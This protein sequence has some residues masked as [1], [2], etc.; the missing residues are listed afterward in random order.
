MPAGVAEQNAKLTIFNAARRPALLPFDAHR[1]RA[2]LEQARLID[3]QDCVGIGQVLDH[4]GAQVVPHSVGI[5]VSRVEQTLHTVGGCFTK[6]L[7]AV[8]AVFAFHGT[9]PCLR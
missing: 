8:P 1:L 2:L 5:P 4:V 6:L 7:R 3:D 9:A